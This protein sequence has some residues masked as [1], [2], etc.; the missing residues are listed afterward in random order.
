M[1]NVIKIGKPFFGSTD[2]IATARLAVLDVVR[3]QLDPTDNVEI[4]IDD[5]YEVTH[6][7]ILG[8]QKAMISTNLPDGKY[9]EVTYDKDKDLMYIDC[10]VKFK[11]H[12]VGIELS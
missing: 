4:S 9:Y 2:F 12:V 5:V 10:Y 1:D 8:N 6:G 7:Y 3:S 11:Q